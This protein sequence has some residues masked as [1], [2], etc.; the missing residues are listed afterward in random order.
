MLDIFNDNGCS[1]SAQP[2]TELEHNGPGFGYQ[3]NVRERGSLGSGATYNIDKWQNSTLE[4][5]ASMPYHPFTVRIKCLNSKG[6]SKQEQVE[7]TL[8]S[9]EDSKS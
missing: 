3:V 8:Y 4:V 6:D 1:F 7:K 5:P 9:Y 2:M